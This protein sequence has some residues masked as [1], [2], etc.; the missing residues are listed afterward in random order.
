M[1]HLAVYLYHTD[2]IYNR[3]I[4]VTFV[5]RLLGSNPSLG[6][7]EVRKISDYKF[8]FSGF[9][10]RWP[11]FITVDRLRAGSFIQDDTIKIRVY[12][13]TEKN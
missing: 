12:L 5:L 11:M 13:S 3:G 6:D 10:P 4:G 8:R 2:N 9:G 7:D 1:E